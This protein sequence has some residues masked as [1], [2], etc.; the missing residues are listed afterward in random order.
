MCVSTRHRCLACLFHKVKPAPYWSVG[1]V[2]Q[3]RQHEA[4][5]CLT[6]AEGRTLVAVDKVVFVFIIFHTL[7]EHITSRHRLAALDIS[8]TQTRWFGWMSV[9]RFNL[10]VMSFNEIEFV[11]SGIIME[12]NVSQNLLEFVCNTGSRFMRRKDN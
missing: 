6:L 7:R 9:K 5:Q 11:K 3:N 4:A 12:Q 10:Y 2:H 8:L 1:A